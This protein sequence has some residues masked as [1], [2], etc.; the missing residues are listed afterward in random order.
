MPFTVSTYTYD[1][2]TDLGK[3]RFLIG[4]NDFTER[5][6]AMVEGVKPDGT[7]FSDEELAFVLKE[8]GGVAYAVP[9]ALEILAN[10]YGSR[11]D[12]EAGD[13]KE[14]LQRVSVRLE[15]RAARWRRT[16]AAIWAN[17]IGFYGCRSEDDLTEISGLNV[18]DIILWPNGGTKAAELYE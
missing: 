1:I 5:D 18:R 10:L 15:E 14:H 4:D 7:C 12:V 6:N 8:Y 11:A 3:L 16:S 13:Y 9:A 2:T 17:T